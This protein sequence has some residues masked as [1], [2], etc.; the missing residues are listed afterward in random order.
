M[1]INEDLNERSSFSFLSCC[2]TISCC[3]LNKVKKIVDVIPWVA[4]NIAFPLNMMQTATMVSTFAAQAFYRIFGKD[5]STIEILNLAVS[6]FAMEFFAATQ[7]VMAGG[8]AITMVEKFREVMNTDDIT[9][10]TAKIIKEEI[11]L[12]LN[13]G[14]NILATIGSLAATQ[15]GAAFVV[16]GI[17]I[18]SAMLFMTAFTLATI[19]PIYNAY[20]ADPGS[21][22]RADHILNALWSGA[23]TAMYSAIG[24]GG[25]HDFGLPTFMSPLGENIVKATTLTGAIVPVIVGT[26]Q[27]IPQGAKDATVEG[28]KNMA[29][30]LCSAGLFSCCARADTEF[31]YR[32]LLSNPSIQDEL[33]VVAQL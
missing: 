11:P 20:M 19:G 22:A 29:H 30:K 16:D 15:T 1:L 28:L 14:C 4:G 2:S 7:M 10:K 3:I 26:Y 31:A 32:P 21:Q 23:L 5:F 9:N 33:P 25:L 24:M 8:N 6:P 12:L 27:A 18:T 17:A 13:L